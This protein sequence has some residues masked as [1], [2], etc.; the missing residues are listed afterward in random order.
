MAQTLPLQTVVLAR[1]LPQVPVQIS[2]SKP[3]LV[4]LLQ[5]LQHSRALQLRLV[6]LLLVEPQ[7]Q[8]SLTISTL[9]T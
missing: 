1:Q 7:R 4:Q 5:P 8:R 3:A 6:P 2:V 9:L